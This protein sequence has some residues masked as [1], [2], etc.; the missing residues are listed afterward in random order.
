[1][2]SVLF[3]VVCP[4]TRPGE[5]VF[6][7]GLGQ[8]LGEWTPAKALPMT[9]TKE[10]FPEWTSSPIS[11]PASKAI[12]YKFIVRGEKWNGLVQWEVIGKP[13]VNRSLVVPEAGTALVTKSAWAKDGQHLDLKPMAVKEKAPHPATTAESQAL[14]RRTQ[15]EINLKMADSNVE[16]AAAETRGENPLAVIIENREEMKRNFSQSLF[17]CLDADVRKEGPGGYPVEAAADKAAALPFRTWSGS[18]LAAAASAPERHTVE[19]KHI[20]SFSALT[21]MAGFEEKEE[22]RKANNAE[23]R[24]TAA[25]LDVPVVIVSSEIA[26][27]SKTGGLGLVAASYS[28][29]FARKG[30]RTMAISPK[31]KDYA[32]I[33]YIGEAKVHL[34]AREETV[35]YMHKYEDYGDG[36]GTDFVFIEHPCLQRDGGPYN[37][38]SGREYPDNLLRFTLLSLAAMEAPRILKLRGKTYGEKVLFLAND[39]QAGLVPMNLCYKQRKCNAYTE[40]RCMYVVHNFGYQGEYNGVDAGRFYGFEHQACCDVAY[41]KGVNL[42]KGAMICA[43]RVITVSPNYAKE[44]QTPA[45][46]F[47][48]QDFAKAKDQARRLEG[49]LNGIDDCWNPQ[50]DH[51]IAPNYSVEDFERGKRENKV[52]LQKQLDLNVDPNV[53]L[54]GFVGR[55]TWQKGIDIIQQCVDWL[56]TDTGNGVTGRAQLIMMGNGEAKFAN[57]L[58]QAENRHKSRV[59][60]YVGFD[61]KVEHQMMAGCDLFLMPSRYEPCGLPQMYSQQYGTLPIVTATGGLVDSVKDLAEGVGKATG[62]IMSECTPPKAKETL[63][64][65]M[66]LYLKRPADFKTM[67][68][69]AMQTDFYWPHAMDEYERNIDAVFSDPPIVR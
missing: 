18:A 46:G 6:V 13:E 68:R 26:P 20:M 38:S 53:V 1:M 42:T 64:K 29:E 43:D 14:A 63:Y 65:A 56:M 9:T 32:G 59:C 45:G 41:G 30:H 50:T 7:V 11:F 54:I 2:A 8:E 4:S 27:F 21:E 61:P 44:I 40:S 12:D 49:I 16:A 37:D 5:A 55:L 52:A 19:L 62:F 39:W 10:T 34:D 57:M 33:E 51:C 67:Q 25:N 31:Y 66:E 58:R 23:S 36:T 28:Y 22:A 47:K 15:D 69:T 35:K 60:G 3:K 24:Y 17:S 48:L